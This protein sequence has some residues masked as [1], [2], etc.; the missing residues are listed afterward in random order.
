MSE[1]V[2]RHTGPVGMATT[3]D[4]TCVFEGMN[5]I[6]CAQGRELLGRQTGRADSELHII[7]TG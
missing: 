1:P 6:K 4:C 5:E 7:R 3:S 2:K